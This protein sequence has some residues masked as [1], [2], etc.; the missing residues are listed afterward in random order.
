MHVNNVN[1]TTV[2]EFRTEQKTVDKMQ[3][4]VWIYLNTLFNITFV[5]G[6]IIYFS[7]EIEMIP[8]CEDVSA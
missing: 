8:W 7:I 3:L 4:L 2:E 1:P 6:N 5:V